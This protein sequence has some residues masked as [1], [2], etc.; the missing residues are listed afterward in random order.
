[1][2]NLNINISRDTILIAEDRG[3]IMMMYKERIEDSYNKNLR[4]LLAWDGTEAVD[5]IRENHEKI[6][7]VVSDGNLG[8]GPDGIEV[9]DQ[10]L[11]EQIPFILLHSGEAEMVKDAIDIGFEAFD[12]GNEISIFF[13]RFDQILERFKN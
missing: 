11:R 9:L 13:E 8:D 1:M 4:T 7:L 6:L 2:E 5:L 12:K 3:E 10:A